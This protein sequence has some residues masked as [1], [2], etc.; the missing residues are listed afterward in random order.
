MLE[1][2]FIYISIHSDV[3]G[4][5]IPRDYV[6][7]CDIDNSPYPAHLTQIICTVHPASPAPVIS[8]ISSATPTITLPEITTR[9]W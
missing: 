7:H 1:I 8:S 4:T 9:S 5:T 3:S 6:F 2:Q